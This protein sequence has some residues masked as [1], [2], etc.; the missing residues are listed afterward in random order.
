MIDF[1]FDFTIGTL[2]IIFILCHIFTL[3]VIIEDIKQN[4]EQER[5]HK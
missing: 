2:I 1:I 5:R 3:W 4:K